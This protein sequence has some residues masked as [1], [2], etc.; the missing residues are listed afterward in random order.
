M[1]CKRS[2]YYVGFFFEKSQR[3]SHIVDGAA[4]GKSDIINRQD[5]Q[6]EAPDASE[7]EEK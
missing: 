3:I 7:K 4:G 6:G 1:T 2:R 5:E